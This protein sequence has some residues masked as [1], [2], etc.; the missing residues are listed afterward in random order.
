MQVNVNCVTNIFTINIKPTLNGILLSYFTQLRSGTLQLNAFKSHLYRIGY[1][2]AGNHLKTE[3]DV[4]YTYS[5]GAS[6]HWNS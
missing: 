3:V 5:W 2:D 4:G 1:G 6:S